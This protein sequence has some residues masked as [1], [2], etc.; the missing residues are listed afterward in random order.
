VTAQGHTTSRGA[1]IRSAAAS[2]RLRLLLLSYL[3][4]CITEWCFWI[5]PLVWAYGVG[6]VRAASLM[7]VVELVPAMLL[8]PVVATWSGRVRRSRALATGYVAQLVTLTSLG[9]ALIV[10]PPVLVYLTAALACVANSATRP[11]HYAI[12][13]DIAETAEG[14]TASNAMSSGAEALAGFIGPLATGLLMVPSGPA[15]PVLVGA[16]LVGGAAVLVLSLGSGTG[17]SALRPQQGPVAAWRGVI[18][19][20]TA[21]LFAALTFAEYV[22]FGA[23]D[24]LLVVLALDLLGLAQSG[25][26]LLNS[27]VGVGAL[28]GTA[29][30]VVL[31]GQRRLTPAVVGGAV[32]AGVPIAFAGFGHS[33]ATAVFLVAIAGGGRLFYGV[34]AFTL[35]QR[36]VSDRMLVGVFGLLESTMSAGMACGAVLAPVLISLAGAAGAFVAVGLLLPVT[37]LVCVPGLRR[38]DKRSHVAPEDVIRLM[39]VPFLKLLT[40][41]VVERLVREQTR[42]S[43]TADVWL[44]REG[45]TGDAFYVIESGRL[46][47]SQAGAVLRE[48]GPGD[49][50]GELALLRDVPRTASIRSLSDVTLGVLGR[51]AFLTAMT[52]APR[53]VAAAHS[54]AS[55]RYVDLPCDDHPRPPP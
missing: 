47:V 52:G 1:A 45:E 35:L 13:P 3:A 8:A 12:L 44:V 43:I 11:V 46:E 23:L 41:L 53:S 5:A 51:D 54:E 33:I 27:A 40:P 19:E 14:L 32:V 18:K 48:L 30:T 38:A 6:G 28:G 20:P 24:I 37:V 42:L 29:A 34:A 49:W 4:F 50:F 55:V 7:S 21:R 16:G 36:S 15:G 31:V 9:V 26:G 17:E 22:L 10:A 2:P 25:P 39:G